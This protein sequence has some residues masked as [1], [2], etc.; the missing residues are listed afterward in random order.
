MVMASGP[1][2]TKKSNVQ[3]SVSNRVELNTPSS[4]GVVF[5]IDF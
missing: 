5:A 2:N 3:G 4:S 1:F